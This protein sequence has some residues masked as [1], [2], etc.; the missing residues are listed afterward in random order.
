MHQLKAIL[1]RVEAQADKAARRS[2]L[3]LNLVGVRAMIRGRDSA[4]LSFCLHL[5]LYT[6]IDICCVFVQ[7]QSDEFS[8]NNASDETQCE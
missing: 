8:S 7:S 4:T 2:E 3:G 5:A 1:P 6:L